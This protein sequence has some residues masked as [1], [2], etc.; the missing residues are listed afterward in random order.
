MEL[1]V[2]RIKLQAWFSNLDLVIQPS[3]RHT[4][5]RLDEDRQPGLLGSLLKSA[6]PSSHTPVVLVG[7]SCG[8]GHGAGWINTLP[9]QEFTP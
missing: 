1:Q 4:Y 5:R 3:L 8:G 7:I 6:D 2:H 9:E